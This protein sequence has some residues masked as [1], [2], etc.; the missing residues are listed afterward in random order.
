MKCAIKCV[1]CITDRAVAAVNCVGVPVSSVLIFGK[2]YQWGAL[3]SIEW[4]YVVLPAIVLILFNIAYCT[5]CNM[6][7][8]SGRTE[9]DYGNIV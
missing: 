5:L 1:K 8:N 3:K 2:H 7:L 4:G 6:L 9:A